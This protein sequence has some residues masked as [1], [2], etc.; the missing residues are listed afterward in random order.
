MK[1]EKLIENFLNSLEKEKGLSPISVADLLLKTIKKDPKLSD[2]VVAKIVEK[3]IE[4]DSGARAKIGNM[5][6]YIAM[7]NK[8][9][10]EQIISSLLYLSHDSDFYVKRH[11]I[12]V[13]AHIAGWNPFILKCAIPRL[14]ELLSEDVPPPFVSDNSAYALSQIA[15]GSPDLVVSELPKLITCFKKA[16]E[17][18]LIIWLCRI[19]G[20]VGSKYP[21]LISSLTPELISILEGGFPKKSECLIT[22]DEETHDFELSLVITSIGEIAL[23][24][25]SLVKGAVPKLIE[26]LDNPSPYIRASAIEALENISLRNPS[27]VAEILPKLQRL[28]DDSDTE[29]RSNAI[30]AIGH[31]GHNNPSAISFLLAH[32]VSMLSAHDDHIRGAAAQAIGY[33]GNNNPSLISQ[34]S[35][36]LVEMLKDPS[37]YVREC[38]ADA[39]GNI[40]RRKPALFCEAPSELLTLLDNANPDAQAWAA[41][42]LGSLAPI[43]R[44]NKKYTEIISRLVQMLESPFPLTRMCAAE[45]L[46]NIGDPST[47]RPLKE[48]LDK[49]SEEIEEFK[50]EK[51]VKAK[52]LV[53]EAVQKIKN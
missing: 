38:A 2:L 20:A 8:R 21:K 19:F 31:I 15:S 43:I 5:I 23:G 39:I 51:W 37:E 10:S 50:R 4:M 46:G 29:V 44:T 42:A 11:S 45:A 22:V 41:D 35:S 12:E 17:T 30:I 33:I 24:D 16:K 49:E 47:L 6:G 7:K 25:P 48:L 1:K 27:I 34:A 14:F 26:Y 32:L 13:L 52:D 9:L 18:I 28:L 3:S 53:K 40:G 36:K